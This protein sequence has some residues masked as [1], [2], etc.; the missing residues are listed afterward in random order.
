MF[1]PLFFAALLSVGPSLI[2]YVFLKLSGGEILENLVF[3][4]DLLT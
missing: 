1:W 4:G 3:S 2:S